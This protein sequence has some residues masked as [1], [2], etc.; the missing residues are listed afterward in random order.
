MN[1]LYNKVSMKLNCY[2]N[3][4]YCSS[5]IP[6]TCSTLMDHHYRCRIFLLICPLFLAVALELDESLLFVL[7]V[8]VPSRS[9]LLLLPPPAALPVSLRCDGESAARR[10]RILVEVSAIVMVTFLNLLLLVS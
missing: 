9:L 7:E 2:L 4:I 3:Y 6:N 1:F 8:G 5:L 10:R